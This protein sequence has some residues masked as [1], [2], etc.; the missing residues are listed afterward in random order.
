MTLFLFNL[1]LFAALVFLT[2][3]SELIKET[4]SFSL[5]E[6]QSSEYM[7]NTAKLLVG[8]RKLPNS[9]EI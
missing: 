3:V 1:P 9:E 7:L 5:N 6:W 2:V 8:N 4:A